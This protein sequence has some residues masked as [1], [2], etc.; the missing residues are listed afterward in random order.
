MHCLARLGK[1]RLVSARLA[2]QFTAGLVPS[3]LVWSPKRRGKSRPDRLRQGWNRKFRQGLPRQG[4][5]GGERCV[6]GGNC[7]AVLVPSG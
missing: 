1:A 4:E 2:G 5:A 7:H 3:S 6:L